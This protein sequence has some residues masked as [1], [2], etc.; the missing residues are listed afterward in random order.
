MFVYILKSLKDLKTY[1]GF[2]LDVGKRIKEHNQG[3]VDATKHRRPFVLLYK[4]N[5]F[6]LKEA[7]K[8]EKYWKSGAGRRKLKQFFKNGFP[9][10]Q[11]E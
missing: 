10:I 2:S 5:C 9:L 3:K 6:D 1:T 11:N 4:E 8:R 7:K